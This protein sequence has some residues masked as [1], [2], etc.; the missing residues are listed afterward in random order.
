MLVIDGSHGEGGGQV[1]RTSLALSLITQQPFQIKNI[2]ANRQKPGLLRQHLTGVQAAAEI[3]SAEV[4]GNEL[5]SSS[6][7]F[8]PGKV[9]GGSYQFS[10]GT[11]GNTTLVLQTILFPLLL[12]KESSTLILE[13]GTHNSSAPPFPFLEK[14]YIPLLRKM[15]ASVNLQL[16]RYGFYP[17]GGGRVE[18]KVYPTPS[19]Q[20]ISLNERGRI[21][22][23]KAH[24]L[25]SKI[26]G[27]VAEREAKVLREKLTL[28]EE[29][30]QIEEINNSPGPGNAVICEIKSEHL[31]EAF[32]SFGQIG[33]R[34]EQ[35]AEELCKEVRNYLAAQ[36]P[37]GEHL[38]DQLLLPL[39]LARAGEFVTTK[40]SLHTLTNKEVIQKF[41]N[42]KIEISQLTDNAWKAKIG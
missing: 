30:I 42:V 18:V 33:V 27:D 20:P 22:F 31:T 19:L 37:V 7:T 28:S 6:L 26:R 13:G 24:I 39:A 25:F 15:G 14:V 38:A 4:E 23:K 16:E 21:V 35:V 5:G 17:A 2:R 32:T 10:I 11:A 34:A 3:S 29:E 9:R 36:V 12:A 1:L 8:I 40:P 41:L